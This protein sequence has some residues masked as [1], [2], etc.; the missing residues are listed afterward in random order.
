MMKSAFAFRVLAYLIVSILLLISLSSC[1]SNKNYISRGAEID[2]L[3]KPPSATFAVIIGISDYLNV[4]DLQYAHKDAMSFE[5]FLTSKEG[6]RIPQE[7]IFT[8]TNEKANKLNVSNALTEIVRKAQAGDRIYFFFAGHGD[9][10]VKGQ[11]ENGLLLLHNSPNGNY[12]GIIDDVLEINQLRTFF[13]NASKNDVEIVYILDACHSG[14]LSGGEE[15]KQQTAAALMSNWGKEYKILSCQPNQLS[16][17]SKQWGDGRGLFS[18][19]FEIGLKGKADQ[20]KDGAI[21]MLE[22]YAYLL[23]MVPLE[24]DNRQIPL[25]TGDLS[26]VILPEAE[27][28]SRNILN[29]KETTSGFQNNQVVKSITD[30]QQNELYREFSRHLLKKELVLPGYSSAMSTYR[31][32]EQLYPENAILPFMRNQLID[33]LQN[34]FLSIVTPMLKGNTSY[35]TS[36]QCLIASVELD[37]CLSLLGVD[38]FIYP[39]I[40]ARSLYMKAMSLTWA[41]S[42]T[43]YN[44]SWKPNVEKAIRLLEE[45]FELEPNA[46]YTAIALGERY[47]FLANYEKAEKYFTHYLSLRPKDYYAIL[48]MG[49]LY[50]SLEQYE[51]AELLFK[52]LSDKY[53]NT[54][55]YWNTADAM[56]RNQKYMEAFAE[57]EKILLLRDTFSYWFCRGLAYGNMKMADSSIFYYQKALDK[58]GPW[59]PCYNNIGYR[60]LITGVYDSS[61]HYFNLAINTSPDKPL[62]YFNMGTISTLQLKFDEAT[63]YFL[64]GIDK[65]NNIETCF[66]SNSGIYFN[67]RY[68]YKDTLAWNIYNN[69]V[70]IY[71]TK[72][73]LYLSLVYALLRNTEITVPSNVIEELF[74]TLFEFERYE[75]LTWYHYACWKAL[76][77]DRIGALEY[78]EKA[79]EKGF[80][81]RFMLMSDADLNAIRNT[82]KFR[83]LL[84]TYFNDVN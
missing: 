39:N 62:P 15:G 49:N 80:G 76:Q 19:Q 33:S 3:L 52:K 45:S 70:Y 10:E 32:F 63:D 8:L 50:F 71:K 38:H 64:S 24:S 42:E 44:S 30:P 26:K 41:L 7:N 37:S 47:N 5:Q 73:V 60:Y 66:I 4:P 6:G 65:T 56:I 11:K 25:I 74:E 46:A 12:F 18:Y 51:K 72:Y 57:L 40:K 79:L 21:T 48:Q 43:E 75:S 82:N 28:A 69:K 34:T 55:Y 35:S 29:K 53:P 22:L 36:S 31:K 9:M 84:T 20:N 2:E 54:Q 67:K 61:A 59:T 16:I 68:V 58:Y 13:D 77:N 23:K 27:T 83:D 78:L 17:E 1:R 81:N 14:N